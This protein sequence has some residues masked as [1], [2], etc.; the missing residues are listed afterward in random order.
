MLAPSVFPRL[1]VVTLG[2]NAPLHNLNNLRELSTKLPQGPQLM[3][4]LTASR[5]IAVKSAFPSLTSLFP[6]SLVEE[7]LSP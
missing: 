1:V 3:L 7:C 5:A 6:L 2:Q 4:A